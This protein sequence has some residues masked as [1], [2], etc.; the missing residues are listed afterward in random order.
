MDHLYLYGRN[1]N[2]AQL[3]SGFQPESDVGVRFTDLYIFWFAWDACRLSSIH[4]L[5]C[6]DTNGC[7][8]ISLSRSSSCSHT[9]GCCCISLHILHHVLTRTGALLYLP[10]T[11]FIMFWH[12]RVLL[13]LPAHSSSCSDT[14]GCCCISLHIL[15]HVLT[16]TGALLY[17][18]VTFFIKFWHELLL[19]YLHSFV[20]MFWHG[21]AQFI[22]YHV[23]TRTGALLY[24]PVT[25]PSC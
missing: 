23:L 1:L 10:V 22:F 16:R 12:E 2:K 24:L 18:P 17:L 14:N 19:L 3:I 5:S 4:S 9:N 13:Y 6:S 20:I 7:C 11:F 8:C 15:H 21:I 25:F